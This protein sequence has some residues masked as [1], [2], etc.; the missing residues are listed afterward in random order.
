MPIH[1]AAPGGQRGLLPALL[2]NEID[3]ERC[4]EDNAP[5]RRTVGKERT[6]QILLLYFP[7]PCGLHKSNC[8]LKSCVYNA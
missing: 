5:K 2:V 8:G 1:G 7:H 3:R 6:D 4:E